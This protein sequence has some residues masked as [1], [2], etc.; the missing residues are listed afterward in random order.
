MLANSA[1]FSAQNWRVP[2]PPAMGAALM[3]LSAVIVPINEKLI[4]RTRKPVAN[5]TQTSN[6]HAK[7]YQETRL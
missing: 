7:N 4:E 2:L 3:S 1:A 5:T 6:V